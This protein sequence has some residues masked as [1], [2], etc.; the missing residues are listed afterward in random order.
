[1]KSKKNL[2]LALIGCLAYIASAPAQIIYTDVNPDSTISASVSEIIK[3]Y[4]ID[5]D[6]NGI[7]EFEL[8]H[9]NPGPGN[10]D[11]EIQ[12]NSASI[13]D[14]IID[15]NGHSK[16]LSIFDTISSN[17]IQWG[18]DMF[19]ILNSPWYGGG[20]KYFGMRFK[21]TGQWYYGW[22]R[23]NIPADHLSFTIKDYAYNSTPNAQIIAGQIT[24][25]IDEP[26]K[27]ENNVLII[28]PNPFNSTTTIQ[29][30][31]TLNNVELDVFNMHGQKVKKINHVS[32]HKIVMDRDNLCSGIYFFQLSQDNQIISAG[33]LIITD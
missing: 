16:V 5:I 20:D 22:A 26:F 11:V 31:L 25:E 3:S 17:S 18:S 8:R 24:N 28:Y 4:F 7:Y 14:V 29:L 12:Q 13:Q 32:G 30:D 2:L 6:N 23:V 15:V 9:F 27:D 21:K 1:M 10:E 19:G 33:K